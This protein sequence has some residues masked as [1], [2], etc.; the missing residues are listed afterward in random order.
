MI[1]FTPT[2][3]QVSLAVKYNSVLFPF[4]PVQFLRALP[5]QGFVLSEKIGPVP[6]GAR[7]DITGIVGR[8]GEVAIRL[9][10]HRQILG[11]NALHPT[12][13]LDE[14]DSVE[15]LLK[16]EFDF[17]STGLAQYY[18]FLGGLTVMAKGN[19]LESWHTH[20]AQVPIVNTFSEV[21]GTDVSLYGIRLSPKAEVPNQVNWFDIRIEPQILS[22]T[23]RHSIEIVFRHAVRDE[24]FGFVRKLEETLRV[25]LSLV[26]GNYG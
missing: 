2:Y 10:T 6:L 12:A 3:R 5:K 25:F 26:E 16:T 7:F 17:D 8:R 11:V 14:M 22:A 18:E 20:F 19:P 15:S 23:D 9:N 13:V 24:V 1:S 21:L 4:D